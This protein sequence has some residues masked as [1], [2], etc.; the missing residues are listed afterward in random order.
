MLWPEVAALGCT[1][2]ISI[3]CCFSLLAVKVFNI[4]HVC[5][6]HST[7]CSNVCT[8]LLV[9]QTHQEYIAKVNDYKGYSLHSSAGTAKL[10]L[11]NIIQ[12]HVWPHRIFKPVAIKY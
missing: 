6:S 12:S 3:K 5:I 1:S 9:Q 4:S 7:V 8:D 2:L 11:Y 10:V